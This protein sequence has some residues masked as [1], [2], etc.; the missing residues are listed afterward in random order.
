MSYIFS[1]Y[2]VYSISFCTI[3]Y[4][5]KL[6][7]FGNFIPKSNFETLNNWDEMHDGKNFSSFSDLVPRKA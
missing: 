1:N 2:V 7:F 5:N 4:A 6:G 3:L